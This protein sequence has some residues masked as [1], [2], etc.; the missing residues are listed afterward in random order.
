[1]QLQEEKE[2]HF[3]ESRAA[4]DEMVRAKDH[5]IQTLQNSLKQARQDLHAK[6]QVGV[7]LGVLSGTIL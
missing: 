4:F 7:V 1:M 3:H 5:E 2:R 6:N